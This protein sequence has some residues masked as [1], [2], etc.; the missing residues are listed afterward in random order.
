MWQRT[1]VC[2]VEAI[3]V[4][5]DI[6]QSWLDIPGSTRF[7]NMRFILFA[8]FFSAINLRGVQ[9]VL[10]VVVLVLVLPTAWILRVHTFHFLS[11]FELMRIYTF[12]S[13]KTVAL[14]HCT[15][16]C[17]LFIRRES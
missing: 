1:K 12:P 5:N 8:L 14:S 7:Q 4:G 3:K 16:K 6:D 10:G 11:P 15:S 2:K 17:L 9:N 13:V